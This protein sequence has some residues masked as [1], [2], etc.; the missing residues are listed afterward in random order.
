[1][2]LLDPDIELDLSRNIFNPDIY[3]GHAG[4]ERWRNAVEDVWDDFHGTV[5]DIAGQERYAVVVGVSRYRDPAI[6]QLQYA[7]QDAKAFRDFLL[8]PDGGRFQADKILYMVNE[9]AGMKNLRTALY[10]F[11]AKPR[12]EDLVVIYFAGHGSPDPNDRRNLYL[13]PYDTE[14]FNMGGSALPMWEIQD[15]FSRVIKAQRIVTFTDA[16][17]S[18]GI[19][20]ASAEGQV[21]GASGAQRDL[22]IAPVAGNNLINQYLARYT[23]EGKRAV[24]TASD[25]GETSAESRKWGGGHG[26]F[27][28]FLME[29]LKG[30]ADQDRDGTVTAGELFDFVRDQVILATSRQQ[31]PTALPGLARD[32]PLAGKAMRASSNRPEAP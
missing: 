6:P 14:I 23:G 2:E 1:L 13:L 9:D 3:H 17:H 25:I 7:D 19:S 27:T 24:M 20:G 32:M 10:T 29:G 26:V 21:P 18:A 12:K 5:E 22:K 8:S 16:C 4:I 11:L 30:K 28:Y 15:I 31:N